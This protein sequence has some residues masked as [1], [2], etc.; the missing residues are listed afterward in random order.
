MLRT[1]SLVIAITLALL[2]L[3][4]SA[5]W[6]VAGTIT[7]KV[8]DGETNLAL[9]AAD[10][11]V[12]G[13]GFGGIVDRDGTF[14][15]EGVPEGHYEVSASMMGYETRTAGD[16]AVMPNVV[17]TIDFNLSPR[18]LDIGLDVVVSAKPFAK[19]LDKPTSHRTL[20]AQEFQRSP[21]SMEDVFRVM[22]TMPG[23]SSV[24]MT[25]SDIV[26]RGGN[27]MENRTLLEN[28]EIPSPLHFG[29]PG[30]RMGGVS[31][32]HPGL[33]ERVD[34]MTGG[35]PARYG[36]KMSSVMEMKLRDGDD[37]RVR[38][39]VNLNL[40]G[41]SVVV[42]GPVSG[43][44]TM[45]CSVRRGVF[46]FLTTTVGI[47][48]LPAY[49]DIVGKVTYKLGSSNTVSLVGL[50]YP[51]DLEMGADPAGD[52]RH[53]TWSELDLERHDRGG[54]VGVN[55]RWMLGQRGYLLTTASRVTNAWTTRRG[56]LE[57]LTVVG[58]DIREGEFQLKSDLNYDVSDRISLRTGVFGERIESEYRAWGIADTTVTGSVIPG[59]DIDYD[60]PTSYKAGS[61]V[62]TTV[63]PLSRVSLTAG[64]RYDYYDL[65]EESK[66]SPRLGLVLSLTDRTSLNVAYGHYYQTAAPYQVAQHPSNLTLRSSL[67]IHK[68][69]GI[70][71]QLSDDTRVTLEAYRKDL[72]SGFVHDLATREITNEGAGIAR[73]VEFCIQKKMGRNLVGSL[74]YTY[75]MTRLRDRSDMREYFSEF[76]RPHNLTVV[77]SYRLFNDW[78]VGARFHYASGTPYTPVTNAERRDGAWYMVRGLRNS[79][80]YPD[81]HMLDIRVDRT[82]RLGGAT[83]MAYLDVWNVYGQRNVTLYGFEVDENGTVT[84]LTADDG[85]S[86]PLPILGLEARF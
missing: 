58:D 85:L 78:A 75:S 47:D 37:K 32:V 71:H 38:T 25:T 11:V 77:G 23:I 12:A 70:A 3:A 29:R 73:G 50:Y 27:P 56:S 69:V 40:G 83:L 64:L 86:R 53:G 19:D 49:W 13:T 34:F 21:G 2:S 36:D 41:F 80:R 5:T 79:E 72:S 16:V 52:S 33:I 66:F 61:Y 4:L 35:F 62:Q 65:T 74:A 55:W 20:S 10:V 9:F 8:V 51:D 54:A 15:I 39:D 46:D 82:F 76:D 30:G 17:T 43:G 59:Y 22:Q 68:V 7:G 48:A 6:A 81:S 84:R 42:D 60:P 57:G 45:V 31:I 44:G 24:D 28:I 67:S 26:V 14:R 1:R 63:K 18:I